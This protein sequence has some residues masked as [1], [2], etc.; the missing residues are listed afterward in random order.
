MAR[1]AA[2]SASERL[3]RTLLP[4]VCTPSLSS[5]L[6]GR[7]VL[8]RLEPLD[9]ATAIASSRLQRSS[10]SETVQSP[11]L[12]AQ[13]V[14]RPRRE[15]WED[16]DEVER[17]RRHSS[18]CRKPTYLARKVREQIPNVRYFGRRGERAG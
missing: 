11:P 5:G 10:S 4:A 12:S 1:D 7:P 9:R 18:A 2:P 3:L 17:K 16:D 13:P 6:Y 14:K 8:P 15:V